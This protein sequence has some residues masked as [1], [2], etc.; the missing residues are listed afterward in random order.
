MQAGAKPSREMLP[1]EPSARKPDECVVESWL[2]LLGHRWNAL[3]LWHLGAGAKRNRELAEALP[4]ISPKVLAE[5]LDTLCDAGLVT[6]VAAATFPRSVTY[7][8]TSRGRD[9]LAV[10]D[11]LDIWAR[12]GDADRDGI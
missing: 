9:L 11:Q 1:E 10:L 6:R 8:L 5:R 12:S 7:L 3:L 2:A 4:G